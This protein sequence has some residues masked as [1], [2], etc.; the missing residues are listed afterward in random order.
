M[1]LLNRIQKDYQIRK[2]NLIN[3]SEKL[4]ETQEKDR[5]ALMKRRGDLMTQLDDMQLKFHVRVCL[6]F[7]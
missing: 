4:Q 3:Q 7:C 2:N 1:L 5:Q 6:R